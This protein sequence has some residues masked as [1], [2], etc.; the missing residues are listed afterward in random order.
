MNNVTSLKSQMSQFLNWIKR[1]GPSFVI[2][3]LAMN[4]LDE[5]FI[6]GLLAYFGHPIM[7]SLFLIGDLDW[8][9]YPLYFLFTNVI[10]GK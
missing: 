3:A 1:Y 6:P 7:G 5:V 2:Y 8:L 10:G 9:T 4:I